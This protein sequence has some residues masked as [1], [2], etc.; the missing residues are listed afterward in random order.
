MMGPAK[1]YVG[2]VAHKRLRPVP[3]AL[4]YRVF[5]L[6]VDVDR[7]DDVARTCRFLSY[8]RF[9][10]LSLHD[11]DHGR[12]DGQP[13]G[14]AIRAVLDGGGLPTRDRRIHLLAYPRVLGYVFNPLSV[15]YVTTPD[16]ALEALV[17]EVSNTFGERV[18]YV[19]PAGPAQGGI[20]A[21]WCTKA[22]FVSPFAAGSGQYGFR[23][24]PPGPNLTVGVSF[25]DAAGPLIKTHFRAQAQA[26]DDAAI[27]RVMASHPLMT[28]KVMTAIHVE[29]FRLWNKGVPLVEGH[30]SGR[31]SVQYVGSQTA[32]QGR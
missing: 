18:S 30:A 15:Y 8:N 2:T 7:I 24:T 22:M 3:H 6:L 13:I 12:G 20:H 31:Y 1:L 32:V 21:Q 5:A 16:A 26:L 25:Q 11:R 4:S 27:L 23:V 19:L 28:W 14:D 9:N 29:A 17:Y 10:L